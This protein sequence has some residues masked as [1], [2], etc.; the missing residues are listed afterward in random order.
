M[1][2]VN[3]YLEQLGFSKLEAKLYLTLLALGPMSVKELA[4]AVKINRTATYSH[5]TSLLENGV[6][7]S[8]MH[9]SKKQLVAIEPDRLQYL[10]DKKMETVKSLQAQFPNF[11]NSLEASTAQPA[12]SMKVDVKYYNGLNGIKAIY[13]DM[14]KAK[15]I[16]VF[17]T[18]SEI[19]PLFPNDPDLFDNALKRNPDLRIFEIYGDSPNAIK[20]FNYTAKSNRYF[21]KFMPSTVGLASPGIV[22]YNNKVAIVNAGD[23][24]SGVVLYNKDYYTN[25]KKLFDFIWQLLPAPAI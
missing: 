3:T 15:E 1:K 11:V 16:K 20:K 8:I 7:L 19:A 4:D 22:M 6:I 25:S 23:K 10:I 14:F 24:I 18:L 13:E 12:S 9:A 21:Y 17:S 5:I 2:T